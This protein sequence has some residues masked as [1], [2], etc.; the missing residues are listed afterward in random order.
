MADLVSANGDGQLDKVL[1]R[2]NGGVVAVSTS[3][4]GHQL[5]DL[6]HWQPEYERH[7]DRHR[8]FHTDPGRPVHQ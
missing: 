8:H 3:S 4:S 5:F 7:C 2:P 6:P 1:S